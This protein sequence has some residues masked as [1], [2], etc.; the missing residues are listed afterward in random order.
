MLE[1]EKLMKRLINLLKK[2]PDI[3]VDDIS[4]EGNHLLCLIANFIHLGSFFLE[5]LAK[6]ELLPDFMVCT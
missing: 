4:I 6:H 1:H 5:N 3:V 2:N